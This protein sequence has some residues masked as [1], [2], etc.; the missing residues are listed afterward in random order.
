[1]L[2]CPVKSPTRHR[3]D[4]KKVACLYVNNGYGAG[5]E[6]VFAEKFRAAGGRIVAEESFAQGAT[7]L[8]A[9]IAA[10]SAS[11]PDG[12]YMPG[13]PPEMAVALKQMKETGVK[14]P[15]LSVQAF[16]DPQILAVAGDAADGVVYSV[17]TPPDTNNPIVANFRSHYITINGKEPGVCSDTGYDALRIVALAFEQRAT[18]AP[19]IRDKLRLIKDFPGAAG[20]TTFD[21]HGDV[22]R[23]FSFKKIEGG[24]RVLLENKQ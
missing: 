13:Y 23:Q 18:S 22:A 17:P 14:L 19:E 2:F 3:E 9:Q 7:D 21:S 20:P 6:K 16:D 8:R 10:V 4:P 12:I 15:V 11:A 5:L 1:M 24:K